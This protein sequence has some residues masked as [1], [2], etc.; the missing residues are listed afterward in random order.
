M[1][2]ARR[3]QLAGQFVSAVGCLAVVVLSVISGLTGT[4]KLA[5]LS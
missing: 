1:K 2:V 5:P 4:A 3:I